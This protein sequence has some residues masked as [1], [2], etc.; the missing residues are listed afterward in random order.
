M[1][2][3]KKTREPKRTMPAEPVVEWLVMKRM[4]LH[5]MFPRLSGQVAALPVFATRQDAE[6]F[7]GNGGP[8]V[9]AIQRIELYPPKE[10]P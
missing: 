9:M 2:K 1:P 7:D 6:V 8:N 3:R 5:P 4:A 10:K